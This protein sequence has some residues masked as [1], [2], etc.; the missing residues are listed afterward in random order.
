MDL[1]VWIIKDND[2]II[3]YSARDIRDIPR[4]LRNSIVAGPFTEEEYLSKLTKPNSNV[5]KKYWILTVND[6][7]ILE[8]GELKDL[9]KKYVVTEHVNI[10]SGPYSNKSVTQDIIN[11]DKSRKGDINIPVHWIILY[12]KQQS[13]SIHQYEFFY[14]NRSDLKIKIGNDSSTL[15]LGPFTKL[16]AKDYVLK[17][18]H[19]NEENNKTYKYVVQTT[20]I[21]DLSYK[22]SP[23]AVIDYLNELNNNPNNSEYHKLISGPFTNDTAIQYMKKMKE[24]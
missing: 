16:E 6:E 19:N 21:I 5:T 24:Q 13:S 2:K 20:Q 12:D 7:L 4:D 11:A 8:E 15:Y 17:Y 10:L 14:G 23:F 18:F 9:K 1:K 22:K 3:S